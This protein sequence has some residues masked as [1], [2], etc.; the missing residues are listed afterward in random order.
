MLPAQQTPAPADTTVTYYNRPVIKPPVW[1]W[2]IPTYFF[3]G[4]VA[5]AAM[6]LAL[7]V[8]LAGGTRLRRFEERCRWIGAVGGGIG[9]ALLI[10]DL[11][12][13]WRFL[14]MLRVV[15]LTSPMSIGSW[16]LALATP[17]SAGSAVLTKSRGWLYDLGYVAGTGGGVLGM[18]LATYTGVLIGNTAVPV[19]RATRRT[20][21]LLFGASAAASL[22][23]VLD[24]M[25]LRAH[26]R[27]VART[28]GIA[29]RAAEL[30]AGF[31]V[32]CEANAVER[33][34][35]PLCE[36]GTGVLWKAAKI[37]TAASLALALVPGKRKGFRVA[38]GV[39]GVL[40]GLGVRFSIFYAGKASAADPRATFWQQEEQPQAWPADNR[41]TGLRV[42]VNADEPSR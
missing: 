35:R 18:P 38:A 42:P 8:Q 23:S 6:T 19:W 3:V 40:G 33:V 16:V 20:L 10:A 21:P 2:T 27:E 32:E 28:F 5:G 13:K 22:G 14:A 29:G 15:R 4:G 24:L 31:A 7:A 37:A 9:T 25:P 17:L 1:I 11:G 34:G 26:E 36:G 30:A 41:S 39:L 12:R